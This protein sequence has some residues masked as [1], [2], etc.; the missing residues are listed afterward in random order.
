MYL[1]CSLQLLRV[2][3]TLYMESV[4]ILDA[5]NNQQ[6][7]ANNESVQAIVVVGAPSCSIHTIGTYSLFVLS[8]RNRQFCLPFMYDAQLTRA[9]NVETDQHKHWNAKY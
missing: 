5:T 3:I 2:H 4:A 9:S 8:V 7:S 6:V 1:L